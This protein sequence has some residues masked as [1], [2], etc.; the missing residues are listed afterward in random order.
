MEYING[1]P[2]LGPEF[3]SNDVLEGADAESDIGFID[4][5]SPGL[6]NLIREI[7]GNTTVAILD[8]LADWGFSTRTE[9]EEILFLEIGAGMFTIFGALIAKAKKD[10]ESNEPSG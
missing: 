5:K 10:A 8:R 4:L 2:I 6:V 9:D 3:D 1:I 7:S